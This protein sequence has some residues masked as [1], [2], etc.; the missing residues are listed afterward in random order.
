[1]SNEKPTKKQG[2][3]YLDRLF[4]KDSNRLFDELSDIALGKHT[5]EVTT[6]DRNGEPKVETS[7]AS[8][9][10]RINA[11]KILLEYHQGKPEKTVNHNVRTEAPKWNPDALSLEELEQLNRLYKKASVELPGDVVEG[12]FTEEDPE[13]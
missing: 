8:W 9:G 2:L 4:G 13:E 1:M 3:E 11:L 7:G 6:L 5:Q 12:E 10:D